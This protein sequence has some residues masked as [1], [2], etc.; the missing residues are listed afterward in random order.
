V[1]EL[2]ASPFEELPPPAV[3]NELPEVPPDEVFPAVLFAVVF[4]S[5]SP[6]VE[7]WLELAP[8][9]GP[10]VDGAP[11]APASF[12]SPASLEPLA[13]PAAAPAEE[14]LLE[15]EFVSCGVHPSVGLQPI[16]AKIKAYLCF[17]MPRSECARAAA[18]AISE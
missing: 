15:E 3:G 12:A 10:T 7:G 1:L 2:P 16:A 5:V 8:P 4:S 9:T 14:L 6:T 17:L 18:K 13:P 11:A